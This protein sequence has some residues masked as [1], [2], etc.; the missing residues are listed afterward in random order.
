MP[1]NWKTYKLGDVAKLRKMNIA[2]QN[3]N[4]EKYIGLEHIG[5]GNFLLESIGHATDVTSNKSIFNYGDILYGKIR[6]YFKKHLY[7]SK[8]SDMAILMPLVVLVACLCN[9]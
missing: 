1:K 7:H 5:Q 4:D 6:P 8:R 2:P 9:L 3:F